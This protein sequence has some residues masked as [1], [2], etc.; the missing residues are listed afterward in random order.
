[1]IVRACAVLLS[2]AVC[3]A[4]AA[5]SEPTS[6]PD[7]LAGAGLPRGADAGK[8]VIF[9][10]PP[11]VSKPTDTAECVPA[12]PCGARLIGTNQRSGAVAIEFPAF[13]W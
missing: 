9:T 13:R 8:P 5:A 6:A 2:S 3:I 7:L 1:M 4:T 10:P 12:L 11:I